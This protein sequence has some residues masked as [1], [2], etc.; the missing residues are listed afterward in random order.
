MRPPEY[1]IIALSPWPRKWIVNARRGDNAVVET[2]RA[3]SR[4][5][6]RLRQVSRAE[7][8]PEIRELY[9]QFFG[10]RDPV[11]QPGTATG[12]PG[13][14]W[15]TFALVPDLLFQARNSLMSFVP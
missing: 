8:S 2:G 14:Y 12:T 9:K 4:S 11:A 1:R 7:A 13:D 5:M 10:D 3:G 15:T 6:G